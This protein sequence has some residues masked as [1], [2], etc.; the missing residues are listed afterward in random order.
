MIFRPEKLKI[1]T[2]TKVWRYL[3][4][5]RFI[6]FLETSSLHFCRLNKL[7]DQY[8]GRFPEQMVKQYDSMETAEGIIIDGFTELSQRLRV[9]CWH[10]SD[11]ESVAMW[12]IYCSN[13]LGLAIQTTFGEL[14]K[15]F[16]IG[17]ERLDLVK[18]IY[19]PLDESFFSKATPLVV[20]SHKLP[21]YSFENELRI[22]FIEGERLGNPIPTENGCLLRVKLEH[23]LKNVYL[24]PNVPDGFFSVIE[25]LRDKFQLRFNIMNSIIK[26][27]TVHSG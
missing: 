3:D 27:Y 12:K 4:F 19:K 15:A 17:P 9:N 7:G 1:P 23:L 25:M 18:V 20:A 26:D 21:S 22:I 10:M 2:D 24:S 6:T 14:I 11:E 16:Y 5:E 8:D 13:N